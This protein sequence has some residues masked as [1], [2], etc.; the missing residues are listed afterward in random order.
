M[1]IVPEPRLVEERTCA[2]SVKYTFKIPC[3]MLQ[4]G[5]GYNKIDNRFLD[6]PQFG[7][8][9]VYSSDW[10][11]FFMLKHMSHSRL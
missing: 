3:S 5:R 9:W 11:L 10:F 8:C 7:D 4:Y 1:P 2:Y 6:H